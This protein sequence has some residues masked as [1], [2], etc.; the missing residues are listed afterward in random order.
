MSSVQASV[1]AAETDS[2]EQA[3]AS[4]DARVAAR[5]LNSHVGYLTALRLNDGYRRF[6][7]L[8]PLRL[9]RHGAAKIG[10]GAWAAR[11]DYGLPSARRQS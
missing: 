10:L 6:A 5:T 1:G 7:N 4:A 2:F 8:W 11:Y 3:V 9:I